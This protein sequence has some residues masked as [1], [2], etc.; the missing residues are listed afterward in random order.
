MLVRGC[1]TR[2][3]FN[4]ARCERRHEVPDPAAASHHAAAGKG[5][6]SGKASSKKGSVSTLPL[7]CFGTPP[8]PRHVC[9]KARTACT[10]VRTGGKRT[11]GVA[12]ARVVR[13]MERARDCVK[14]VAC[15]VR[16]LL[17]ATQA[18]SLVSAGGSGAPTDLA[19]HQA[20]TRDQLAVFWAGLVH[21]KPDLA[22]HVL[23]SHGLGFG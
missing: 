11:G 3:V 22:L 12:Q 6:K 1:S 13:P 7:A 23:V 9:R 2:S 17:A 19:Q 8:H 15:G 10:S 16:L 4:C 21:N 14:C 5:A 20:R 18:V